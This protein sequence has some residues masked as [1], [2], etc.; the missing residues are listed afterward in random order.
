MPTQGRRMLARGGR[1]GG[2]ADVRRRSARRTA[3]DPVRASTRVE[4][5]LTVPDSDQR[6]LLSVLGI[7]SID[8]Q[9]RQV[10]FLDTPDLQLSAA[11]L[12][13]R[14]RRTQRKSGD[15]TVKLRPMLPADVPARLRGLPG[16]KVEVDASPTGFNCSCSLTG[17]V[18]DRKVKELMAGTR[19]LTSVLTDQQQALLVERLPAGLSA[20]DLSVLGPVHLLKCKFSPKG[21][22]HKLV[23]EMWLL[24]GGQRILELSTKCDQSKAFR[25]AAETKIFLASRGV[26]LAAPQETKTKSALAALAADMMSQTDRSEE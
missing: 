17:E 7:D 12:V 2:T 20:D 9:I 24:P 21:Y 18:S 22:P 25:T 14:A 5:K 4:L 13:V 3:G 11:G 16:F 19:A 10:A 23:A 8:A 15:V 1:D 6:P 26:D